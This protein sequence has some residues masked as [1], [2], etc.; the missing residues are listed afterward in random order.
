MVARRRARC[1]SPE[2]RLENSESGRVEG[3]VNHAVARCAK[4]EGRGK[5]AVR[6]DV[7]GI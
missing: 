7:E 3:A 6:D 1:I 5:E 2:F 4:E